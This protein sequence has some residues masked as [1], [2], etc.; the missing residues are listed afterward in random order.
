[1][2]IISHIWR[3][4]FSRFP[5]DDQLKWTSTQ[6]IK[7]G[8]RETLRLRLLMIITEMRVI[9]IL[10][11]IILGEKFTLIRHKRIPSL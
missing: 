8:H 1:M 5:A 10:Q 11:Q 3:F 7:T 4:Y 6:K 9:K 2:E